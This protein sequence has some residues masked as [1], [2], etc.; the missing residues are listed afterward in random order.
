MKNK[1]HGIKQEIDG[2]ETY[3]DVPAGHVGNK[4]RYYVVFT[5][6][7]DRKLS[8]PEQDRLQSQLEG[9]MVWHHCGVESC[10]FTNDFMFAT[11]LIP[12]DIASQT[13]I[14]AFLD[15]ASTQDKVL[16]Y[17][18]YITNNK[19][20]PE[21]EDLSWYLKEAREHNTTICVDG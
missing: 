21:K 9:A 20:G 15:I 1:F 18:F 16:R 13:P 6:L 14:D 10:K 5:T 7:D 8:K 19:K 11:I 2:D 17:Y 3:I 4:L 12:I